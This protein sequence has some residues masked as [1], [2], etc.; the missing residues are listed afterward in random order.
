MIKNF[1]ENNATGPEDVP[2]QLLKLLEEDNLEILDKSP[3]FKN[4]NRKD[5]KC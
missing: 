2:V 3:Q 4:K 1:K 5:I